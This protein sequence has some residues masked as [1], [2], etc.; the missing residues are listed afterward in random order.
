MLNH[1]EVVE[2]VYRKLSLPTLLGHLGMCSYNSMVIGRYNTWMVTARTSHKRH[3]IGT[4]YTL[5]LSKS[6]IGAQIWRRL[7]AFVLR[8]A[9][10]GSTT[11]IFCLNQQNQAIIEVGDIY[12]SEYSFVQAPSCIL[13][14]S[15]GIRVPFW[16]RNAITAADLDS[17]WLHDWRMM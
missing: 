15:N 10:R 8:Y 11:R 2:E 17:I 13:P 7:E 9:S 16:M 1:D 4:K 6:V 3:F 5:G 12:K 14:A